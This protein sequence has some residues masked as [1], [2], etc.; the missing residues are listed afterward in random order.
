MANRSATPKLSRPAN[1][2]SVLR[3][4]DPN[5]WGRHLG[6]IAACYPLARP[7]ITCPSQEV[8]RCFEGV[9]S[10]ENGKG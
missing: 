4:A 9:T 5:R 1:Q 10:G 3:P 2:R 8:T 6:R 7:G